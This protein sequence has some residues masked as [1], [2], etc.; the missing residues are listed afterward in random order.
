MLPDVGLEQRRMIGQAVEDL[1]RRQAVALQH[2]FHIVV[3]DDLVFVPFS[4]GPEPAVFRCGGPIG[5]TTG[6]GL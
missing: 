1:R 2:H 6:S 4:R 3:H 5:R